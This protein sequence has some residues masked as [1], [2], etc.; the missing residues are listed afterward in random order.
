MGELK[1]SLPKQYKGEGL[2]TPKEGFQ[3]GSPSKNM[4]FKK[5]GNFW[6]N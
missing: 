5:I 4:P 6:A 1:I 3:Q 2:I